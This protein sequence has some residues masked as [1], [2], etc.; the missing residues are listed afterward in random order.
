MDRKYIISILIVFILIVISAIIFT[1]N[2]PTL[3]PST[4]N[5]ENL[6]TCNTLSYNSEDAI[7]I[8]F[9]ATEKEAESYM[10]GFFTISPLKENKE[11]FN[12][13]YISDYKP[14]CELYKD[15]AVFCHTKELVQKS[16]SCPN[17]FIIALENHPKSI[18]SSAYLNVISLNSNHP[19]S[20]LHHEFG[21]VF[22]NLAEEYT[23]AN[24]AKNSENCVSSCEEFNGLN[25]GC[26]EGCTKSSLKRS[27]EKGI[28]RSTYSTTYGTFN[29]NLISQKISKLTGSSN[30]I[31]G[32]VIANS[33]SDCENQKYY[34]IESQ[35]NSEDNFLTITDKE[36]KTGCIP[37]SQVESGSFTYTIRKSDNTQLTDSEF[38]P[39]L[40]YTDSPGSEDLE[41]DIDGETLSYEGLFYKAIPLISNAESLSISG[42]INNIQVSTQTSLANTGARACRI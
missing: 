26:F 22:A 18:R 20:V 19:I 39:L 41:S 21:H 15:I 31:T 27:I 38:N 6:E 23:P 30:Y 11:K 4:S 33:P 35:I 29:S 14:K 5:N 13:Y 10:S 40:I 32:S 12:F 3:S 8:V 25:E 2:S 1:L 24:L 7:N 28:M 37:K 17:D 36:I 42:E 34:L 16:A 9:F